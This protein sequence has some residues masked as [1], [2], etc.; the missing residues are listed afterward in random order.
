MARPLLGTLRFRIFYVRRSSH[1]S[2]R[3]TRSAE[4]GGRAAA[5][6]RN[7]NRPRSKS[8]RAATAAALVRSARA[9]ARVRQLVERTNRRALERR[10][11]AVCSGGGCPADR[12]AVG[13]TADCAVAFGNS[14]LLLSAAD[15]RRRRRDG[16]RLSAV[17]LG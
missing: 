10:D 1:R 17:A 2:G 14:L 13:R 6:P 16:L 7:P 9:A 3:R 8:S 11:A 12:A 15:N 4:I 5:A